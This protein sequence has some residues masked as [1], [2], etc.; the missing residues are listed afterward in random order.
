MKKRIGIFVPDGVGI[1]N[2]LFSDFIKHLQNDGGEI[3]ILHN[4]SKNAIKEVSKLHDLKV[5]SIKIPAYSETNIEKFLREL[6]TL[7]RLKYFSKKLANNTILSNWKRKGNSFYSK[8]FYILIE[9]VAKI[10]KGYD[11]ISFIHKLYSLEVRKS[12][13]FD[14][15]KNFLLQI[16]IDII[17]CTHQRA[18][19]ASPFFEA[20]NS[21]NITSV[22]AIYSWDNLPKAR[23]AFRAD[24][25]FVWSDYMK[26]EMALYYPEIDENKVVV[27]G[28]PQFEFYKKESLLESR[29][30]F[31]EKYKLNPNKKVICYS[32]GDRLTSPYDQVYLHD[33]AVSLSELPESVRPQILFRRC[34]VDWSDRFDSVLKEFEGIIVPI[35]PLWNFEKNK[36]ETWTLTYPTYEDVKL[37][38]NVAYHC[39]LVYNVGSTMA[40][41]YAMFKKPACYINYNPDELINDWNIEKIYKFQHFRSMPSKN[42]VSWINNKTE[43]LDKVTNVLKSPQAIVAAC[44]EWTDLIVNKP[45]EFSSRCIANELIN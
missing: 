26:M 25:Y 19:L 10:I 44:T 43:I 39:D 2:Y 3:V 36:K 22:T 45:V 7:M 33:L 5:T 8:L 28:T 14:S 16:N 35:D 1:R 15:F 42:A 23:L 40:H 29:E 13:Y 6:E 20:A 9:F 24:K 18:L 32:G 4:I 11:Q 12:Q 34:P 30:S 31:F 41:D 38:V 37:L 27:T 17:F 21:L